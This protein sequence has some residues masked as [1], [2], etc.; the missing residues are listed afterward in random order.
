[1]FDTFQQLIDAW[2]SL[3]DFASDLGVPYGT[4]K[5][6]RRRDSIASGHWAKVVGAAARREIDG[7]TFDALAEIAA[8]REASGSRAA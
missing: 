5:Q 4:A 2:P 3:S 7:V 8:S 1:M 6:M